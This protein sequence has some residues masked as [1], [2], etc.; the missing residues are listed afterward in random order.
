M[1]R[2]VVS[3]DL[4]PVGLAMVGWKDGLP[5]Y[6]AHLPHPLE[7]HFVPTYCSLLIEDAMDIDTIEVFK[8]WD[9]NS[10]LVNQSP[11]RIGNKEP[12]PSQLSN[13]A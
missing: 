8:E 11:S 1:L 7:H 2:S 5:G 12:H 3:K 10:G 9:N 6:H 4:P 13:G